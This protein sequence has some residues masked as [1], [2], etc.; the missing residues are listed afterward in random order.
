[1]PAAIPVDLDNDGKNDMGVQIFR[2]TLVSNLNGGSH[3]EQLDQWRYLNSYQ[4]DDAGQ[5]TEGAFLVYAPDDQ[6]G[7]PSGV[8]AD[9]LIFTADDNLTGIELWRSDGSVA[10]TYRLP[11]LAPIG[12]DAKLIPG[13]SLLYI[14]R[15]V[16]WNSW[17]LWQ[18]NGS[19]VTKVKDIGLLQTETEANPAAIGDKVVTYVARGLEPMRQLPGSI[20]IN[21]SHDSLLMGSR[22][23]KRSL[24]VDCLS[25][26][27]PY[28]RP[29]ISQVVGRSPVP[30]R[31][32]TPPPLSGPNTDEPLLDCGSHTAAL[33]RPGGAGRAPPAGC[34]SGSMAP[35]LQ[36]RRPAGSGD[37]ALQETASSPGPSASL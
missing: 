3:L 37:P 22:C 34:Q 10:G 23:Q 5:I 16:E 11:G 30:A 8:G 14:F 19:A 33:E 26:R 21:A 4:F 17:D 12:Y 13:D 1:M 28:I 9:G 32:G 25:A 15:R 31:P 20:Q 24:S 2:L 7:F 35:A 29:P 27:R 36:S 18:A 6:Q